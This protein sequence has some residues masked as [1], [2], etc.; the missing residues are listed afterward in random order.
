VACINDWQQVATLCVAG[1]CGEP[2]SSEMR[3]WNSTFALGA[4]M[5]A[6]CAPS[7]A[8]DDLPILYGAKLHDSQITIEVSSFGCTDA[9]YF[10]VR[11]DPASSNTYHLSVIR[12]K[13]DRCRMAAHV[14]IVTLNVPEVEDTTEA[15]YLLMNRFATG[16]GLPRPDLPANPR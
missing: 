9:S 2:N 7:Q 10:S 14:T 15:K 3:R 16:S 4:I 6:Q 5:L 8:D 12:L 13:S 11:L 1:A